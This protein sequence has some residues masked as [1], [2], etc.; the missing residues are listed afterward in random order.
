MKKKLYIVLLDAIFI[1]KASLVKE[2]IVLILNLDILNAFSAGESNMI[3]FNKVMQ[4]F[5]LNK[6]VTDNLK[7]NNKPLKLNKMN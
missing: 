7:C 4:L 6:K 3:A 2:L 1:A 5:N